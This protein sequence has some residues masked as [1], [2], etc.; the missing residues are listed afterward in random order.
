MSRKNKN[1][2]DFASGLA[3]LTVVAIGIRIWSGSWLITGLLIVGGLII[4][5]LLVA[6][7]LN[8]PQKKPNIKTTITY[9]FSSNESTDRVLPQ[10]LDLTNIKTGV[11]FENFLRDIFTKVGYTTSSIKASGDRGA[12]LILTRNNVKYVVRAKFNSKPVGNTA[13]QEAYTAKCIYSADIAAVITNSTFTA[14]AKEDA[15]SVNV[16]LVN[17]DELNLLVNASA[18]NKFFDVFE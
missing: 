16:A 7:P 14:Q 10:V 1:N 13:I 3:F 18:L 8:K 12:D 9:T 5:L 11:D 6:K 4:L 17:G 2:D 15:K